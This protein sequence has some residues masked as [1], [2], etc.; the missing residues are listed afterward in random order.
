MDKNTILI[1]GGIA[2]VV[3]AMWYFNNKGDISGKDIDK[4]QVKIRNAGGD[5]KDNYYAIKTAYRKSQKNTKFVL[6]S[7]GMINGQ[8]KCTI[9]KLKKSDGKISAFRCE[10]V[11]RG[12]YNIADNSTFTF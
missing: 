12:S 10:E 7:V 11:P 8:D 9:S 1:I 6:G 5:G 3:G 2:A 4:G